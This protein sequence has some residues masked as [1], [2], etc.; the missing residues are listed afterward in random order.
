MLLQNLLQRQSLMPE[1]AVQVL[2]LGA[3]QEPRQ[4]PAQVVKRL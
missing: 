3:V 4:E 1:R 2:G